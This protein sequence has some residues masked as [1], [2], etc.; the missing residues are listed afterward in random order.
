MEAEIGAASLKVCSFCE[1]AHGAKCWLYN[2][3][4]LVSDEGV[5]IGNS[6]LAGRKKQSWALGDSQRRSCCINTKFEPAALPECN[7]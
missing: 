4:M 7:W 1:D 6:L 3:F 2:F 5:W